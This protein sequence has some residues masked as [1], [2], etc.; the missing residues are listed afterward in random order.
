M[1]VFYQGLDATVWMSMQLAM[2]FES[3]EDEIGRYVC[4]SSLLVVVVVVV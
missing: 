2:I 4:I 1:G 3:G